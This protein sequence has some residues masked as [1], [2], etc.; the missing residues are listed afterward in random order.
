VKRS[1]E[2]THPG[3]HPT[4]TMNCSDNSGEQ[5]SQAVRE[6][7][8]SSVEQIQD[9][10]KQETHEKDRPKKIESSEII[11]VSDDDRDIG[12][13]RD[14]D[15]ERSKLRT[16]KKQARLNIHSGSGKVTLLGSTTTSDAS[17]NETAGCSTKAIYVYNERTDN[18]NHG[19]DESAQP[20]DSNKKDDSDDETVA[21][22][23]EDVIEQAS[24]D[25][26][27]SYGAVSNACAK[28]E[29]MLTKGSLAATQSAGTEIRSVVDQFMLRGYGIPVRNDQKGSV[30]SILTPNGY[31]GKKALQD[32]LITIM[33]NDNCT[34]WY[35][36]G[37]ADDYCDH[38]F[39]HFHILHY[40]SSS[41]GDSALMKR[42]CRL[43]S[44]MKKK[45]NAFP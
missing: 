18:A 6:C 15:N 40:T 38:K 14:V 28:I 31:L 42:I 27:E 2:S 9:Q 10:T 11:I 34:Y 16:S 30:F 12:D 41:W 17:I 20:F 5:S 25:A 3:R 19:Y 4:P 21:S 45:C 26:Q 43:K 37:Q 29:S 36:H 13:D 8:S 44:Q 39:P 35:H 24:I 1:G 22:I 23:P 32:I 33:V 7:S